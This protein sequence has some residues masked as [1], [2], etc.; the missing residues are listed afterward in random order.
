MVL[1]AVGENDPILEDLNKTKVRRRKN[2]LSLPELGHPASLALGPQP[3]WFLGF[4]TQTGLTPSAALV[5]RPSG[6]E[7]N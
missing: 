6:Q 3:T 7:R 4:W 2:S 1:T 5:L